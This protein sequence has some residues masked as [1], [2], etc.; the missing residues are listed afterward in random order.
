VTDPRRRGE[1]YDPA[2]GNFYVNFTMPG[3]ARQ[4]VAD[5][6][7]G[8]RCVVTPEVNGAVVVFDEESEGQDQ[9]LI[10]KFAAEISVRLKCRVWAVLNHDDDILWYRLYAHG[11]LEDAYDSS[12]GYFEATPTATG[13]AGG[14]ASKL[15]AAFGATDR[16][17]VERILRRPA[18]GKN[19]YL[20]AVERHS[21]LVR[22]LKTSEFGVGTSFFTFDDPDEELPEGL[23]PEQVIRT[24]QGRRR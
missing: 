17:A 15:C 20:F 3:V 16:A 21:A 11:R 7:A 2:M 24:G 13:P 19:G 9:D 14:N 10:S 6:L 22:A 12:P 18:D 5:A 1:A 4:A 23:T 8:R